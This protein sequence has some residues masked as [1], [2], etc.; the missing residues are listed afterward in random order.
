MGV[1]RQVAGAACVVAV[2]L[3]AGCGDDS[4]RGSGDSDRS[5]AQTA[6]VAGKPG[7]KVA[8]LRKLCASARARIPSSEPDGTRA[9]FRAQ[10][11][12]ELAVG[13]AM[14]AGDIER[15]GAQARTL[16]SSHELLSKALVGAATG[17]A[18]TT[19]FTRRQIRFLTRGVRAQ[20]VVA[21]LP[22]CGPALP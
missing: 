1:A 5:T 4:E 12:G 18:E 6:T 22:E 11:A 9:R 10:A 3:A 7:P 15:A 20:A 21:K 8:R 2:A 17:P 13:N 19:A 16:L 14:R